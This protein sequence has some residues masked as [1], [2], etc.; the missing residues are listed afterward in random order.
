MRN[1]Y[2]SLSRSGRDNA[3]VRQQR[4]ALNMQLTVH[5]TA[6]DIGVRRCSIDL[7]HGIIDQTDRWLVSRSIGTVYSDD[8]R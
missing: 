5:E 2:L 7:V 1:G 6:K 8:G 3:I 4:D